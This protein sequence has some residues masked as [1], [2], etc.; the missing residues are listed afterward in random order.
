MVGGG[1]I[2]AVVKKYDKKSGVGYVRIVG[3]DKHGKKAIVYRVDIK[4]V[5]FLMVGD[6]IDLTLGKNNHC[7]D[8]LLVRK[9]GI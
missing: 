5:D 1:H 4:N 9:G 7:Y 2:K 6:L 8:V 3:G